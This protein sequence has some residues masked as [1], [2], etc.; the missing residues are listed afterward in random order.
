MSTA[1][2]EL[3]ARRR[4]AT[5]LDGT[6]RPRILPRH[7]QL[8]WLRLAPAATAPLVLLSIGGIHANTFLGRQPGLNLSDGATSAESSWWSAGESGI[9]SRHTLAGTRGYGDAAAGRPA[10]RLLLLGSPRGR[11]ECRRPAVQPQ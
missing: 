8:G 7:F 1:A 2:D 4:G 5:A 9:F 3:A 11:A 10:L 6:G